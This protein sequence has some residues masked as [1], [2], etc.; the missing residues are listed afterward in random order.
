MSRLLAVGIGSLAVF[1]LF[2]EVIQHTIADAILDAPERPWEACGDCHGVD[3]ISATAHF[4]KL[5]GQ[6]RA[7]VEK[8]LRDFRSGL[9]ANDNGQMSGI[10]DF[11]N[12]ALEL[13]AAYFSQLPAPSPTSVPGND[14]SRAKIIFETGL[15]EAGIVACR[16]CHNADAGDIPWLDAQHAGYLAK[17]LKDFKSGAR[18]ND[19]AMAAIARR[20]SDADIEKV[21][22]YLAGTPRLS[23]GH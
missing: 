3:G 22:H 13:A 17:Q 10:G 20:L 1:A 8:E 12:H 21:A 14:A 4:P 6:K 2:L 5:A 18:G 7:Y 11:S 9:R 15:P 23:D 19:N 16:S